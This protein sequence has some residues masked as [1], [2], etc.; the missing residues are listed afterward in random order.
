M[1]ITKLKKVEE[2][3]KS[4]KKSNKVLWTPYEGHRIQYTES[5]GIDDFRLTIDYCN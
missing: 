5:F 1:L 2:S 4:P 3:E